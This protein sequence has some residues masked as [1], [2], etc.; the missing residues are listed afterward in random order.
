ME[1]NNMT[2]AIW[3]VYGCVHRQW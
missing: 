2:W 3:M 1:T